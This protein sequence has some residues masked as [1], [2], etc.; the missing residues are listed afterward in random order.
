M[1]PFV[2]RLFYVAVVEDL[3]CTILYP[4]CFADKDSFIGQN[5]FLEGVLL[6][7]RKIGESYF[8]PEV[9]IPFAA[10]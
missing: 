5:I 7:F 8:N 1:K 6:L 2:V 3:N 10:I 4:G 9:V